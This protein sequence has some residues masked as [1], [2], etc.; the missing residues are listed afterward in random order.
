METKRDR[1]NHHGL[2]HVLT[3]IQT[4]RRW[5]PIVLSLVVVESLVPTIFHAGQRIYGSYGP[6]SLLDHSLVIVR[7][8]LSEGFATPTNRLSDFYVKMALVTPPDQD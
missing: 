6:P 7:E 4:R 8:L 1:S 3:A 2:Q 5:G